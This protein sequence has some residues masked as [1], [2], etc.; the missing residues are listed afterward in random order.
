[1]KQHT[2]QFLKRGEAALQKQK[3]TV[4][5]KIKKQYEKLEVEIKQR[6]DALAM[7]DWGAE[8]TPPSSVVAPLYIKMGSFKMKESNNTINQ[9]YTFPLLL[10]SKCNA[11]LMDMEK[12]TDKVPSLFQSIILRVLMSM[13]VGVV[14]VSVIDRDFGLRFPLV[15]AIKNPSIKCEVKDPQQDKIRQLVQEL[16][17]E[18]IEATRSFAGRYD[19]IES[20][21]PNAGEN[22]SPYH[23]VFIDD[24]PKGFTTQTVDELIRLIDNGVA[25]RV[26]IKIF[27]NYNRNNPLPRDFDSKRFESLC[28]I[29]KKNKNDVTFHN[30]SQQFPSN[31]VPTLDMELPEDR[32]TY[33]DFINGMKQKESVC[34]L[35]GWVEEQKKNN[36]VW[37]GDTSNGIKVPVGYVS[38]TETFDFYI[39]NQ[40]DADCKDFF[41]LIAGRP[42]YGKTVLLHNIIVNAA[43]K[44]S[45]EELH[46]YLADFAHGASF[47]SYK[48]LPHV[49]ALMIANNRE[50]TLR[51]LKDLEQETNRRSQLF[52]EAFY[53]TGTKVENLAAYRDATG[54]KLPLIVLIIDEFH[55]LFTDSDFTSIE[56]RSTLCNAIRQWRKF[57]IC[58]ILATQSISGVQFGNADSMITYRFA[59][60]SLAEDSKS[61]IRNS[62][63]QYLTRKGQT[64]MNNTADGSEAANVEFQSAYSAHY[65]KEVTYLAELYKQKY[66]TVHKP[67]I[68]ERNLLLDIAD[69]ATL[70]TNITENSFV[71][72]YQYSDV[73][74]G[75]PDLLRDT[76]T[77][78]RYQRRQFSNTLIVG[79]DL[80]TMAYTMAV[81]LLQLNGCSQQA[82]KFYV[83]DAFNAGDAYYGVLNDITQVSEDF[84]PVTSYKIE[85]CIEE[86][87]A[88]L[89]RRKEAL[90]DGVVCEQ[91]LVLA[92]MN[93]QECDALK[94][95]IGRYG[96]EMSATTQ[97]L[98]RLLN[99]GGSLGIHCII[100]C[101]SIDAMFKTNAIFSN[102]EFSSFMNYIFLK[103]ADAS[104]MYLTSASKIVP[105]EENGQMVVLNGKV[106]GET[107]E[108][109]QCYSDITCSGK[110]N[111]M[112]DYLSSLFNKLRYA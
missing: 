6:E 68:C 49:K 77:R 99:E 79:D 73:Y 5:A 81:Q 90:K 4:Y 44:Y 42:G 13:R 100:H 94:P 10:P 40:K 111:S 58:I 38:K 54:K 85:N 89:G 101:L 56:A 72:S 108:Q 86:M 93:A 105:P 63:A 80:K 66:G 20:Y 45:P 110:S 30:W 70:Y 109:C 107:Y 62:A 76:H 97:N 19:D 65:D 50:Y 82:S 27:I 102:K 51:M 87:I 78:I 23:Y 61:I 22:V 17:K 67:N 21:N 88:E 60:N 95:Q 9:T 33:I 24:F 57:G 92:I 3:E 36:L 43:L 69:N 16:S 98:I 8:L 26:G 1:M 39:A 75:K 31:I 11:V 96:A 53:E 34:S 112:V 59:L 74:V 64:I 14:K 55:Y 28:S 32:G 7:L 47:A 18:V 91:C 2:E 71:K 29:I 25:D 52:Q 48:N 84:I 46:F 83:V 37:T 12:E 103:G 106:D 35:D 104:N 41:A 15:S